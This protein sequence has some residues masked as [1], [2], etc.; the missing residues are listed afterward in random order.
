L[1]DTVTPPIFSPDEETTVPLRIASSARLLVDGS[2]IAAIANPA[3]AM[4]RQRVMTFL[5]S[6][7]VPRITLRWRQRLQIGDN[8]IYFVRP[9]I[10]FESGHPRRAVADDFA[11][12]LGTPP[13]RFPRERRRVKAA[14]QRRFGMADAAGLLEQAPAKPLSV[15]EAIVGLGGLWVQHCRAD[16]ERENWEAASHL[17]LS[18]MR[19]LG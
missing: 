12:D 1:A 17:Q 19:M 9:E 8:G 5:P 3:V 11:D 10:V 2:T 7:L 6:L 18:R 15:A 14:R 4:N 13:E 16:Q